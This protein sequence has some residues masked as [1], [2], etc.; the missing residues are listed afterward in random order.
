MIEDD[1]KQDGW[2]CEPCLIGTLWF[3][4][5]YFCRIDC[6]KNI[7]VFSYDND[8]SPL[9]VTNSIEGIKLIQE[10]YEISDIE[11]YENTLRARKYLFKRRYGHSYTEGKLKMMRETLKNKH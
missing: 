10:R 3:K 2:R 8:M 9:G 1:L 5:P 11:Y 7:I 6:D 4:S